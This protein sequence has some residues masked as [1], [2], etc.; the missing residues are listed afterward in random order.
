MDDRLSDVHYYSIVDYFSSEP[1]SLA[2]ASKFKTLYIVHRQQIS[3]S[4]SLP[5]S[6]G[7]SDIAS[8]A[9]ELSF[10]QE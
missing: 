6:L 8:F 5:A 2:F 4:P 10:T 3:H 7:T 9:D 1:V